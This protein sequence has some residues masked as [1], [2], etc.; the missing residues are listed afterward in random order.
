[1]RDGFTVLFVDCDM[2]FLSLFAQKKE[3]KKREENCVIIVP[4]ARV[5]LLSLAW[6]S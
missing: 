2:I 5:S 3:K 1:M 4:V 6:A